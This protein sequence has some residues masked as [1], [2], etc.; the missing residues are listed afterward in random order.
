[1]G[2]INTLLAKPVNNQAYRGQSAEIKHNITVCDCIY[3][4]QSAE[5]KHDTQIAILPTESN[6]PR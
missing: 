5:L 4:V 1:M 2:S 6:V 3:R